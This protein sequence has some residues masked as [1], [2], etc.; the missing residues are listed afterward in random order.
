M[1]PQSSANSLHG[2]VEPTRHKARV[3]ALLE[4]VAGLAADAGV[5]LG[6]QDA[7]AAEVGRLEH[8]VGGRLVDLGVDGPEHAGDDERPLD[9]GDHE[10]LAVERAL[11]LVQGDD[12]LALLR[13]PHD[14][15]AAA[16]LGGVEGVQ[17]LAPAEHHV[18][19]HVDDVADR[20]HAGVREARL[21]PRRRVGGLHPADDARAVAR[22]EVGVD[23]LDGDRLFGRGAAQHRRSGGGRRR[24]L[25]P[26]RRRDLAGDAVDAEAVGPVR[27]QL[28]L[29]HRLAHRQVVLQRRAD[30]PVGRQHDD[31]GALLLVAELLLAH[32][33]A[34]AL[35]AAQV[36]LLELEAV[37]EHGAAHRHGDHVAGRRSC[38]RRRRS[39]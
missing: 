5:Q 21:E 35:D 19:R 12:L 14:E 10:H 37:L 11:D 4:A 16:D 7:R 39:A 18:V 27:G 1:P 2:E 28:E 29:E 3:E 22:A 24:Q 6:A 26:R 17:G 8:H 20:P 23:D 38:P 25:R 13:P 9:V 34:V 33:H 15:R 30:L 36:G 32:H 31:A